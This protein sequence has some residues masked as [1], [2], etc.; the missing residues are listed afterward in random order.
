[1]NR[2]RIVLALLVLAVC[3]LYVPKMIWPASA[4][5]TTTL[6]PERL[7]VFG[8]VC[9]AICLGLGAVFSIRSATRIGKG[10]PAV[11]PRLCIGAWLGLWTVGQLVM[12]YYWLAAGNLTVPGPADAAFV[13]GYVALFVGQV[14]F[15]F[16]YRASGLPVGSA[17]EHLTIAAAL[18]IVFAVLSYLLLAPIARSSAPWSERAVNMAY[19]AIDLA[20]LVPTLIMLRI[21]MAFRPGR[22]WALWAAL[23]VG[24]IFMTIGDFLYA[25]LWDSKW[26]EFDPAIHLTYLLGYVFAMWGAKLEHDLVTERGTG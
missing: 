7:R 10:N 24:F 3:A 12:I 21:A 15:I 23:L 5:Y 13:L 26:S 19:P 25:Y 6:S 9:K 20:E 14:R 16:V 4:F 22:V 11:F 1:M 2:K 8:S 18:T 17:R